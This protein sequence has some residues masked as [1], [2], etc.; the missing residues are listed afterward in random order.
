[1]LE[2]AA[3]EGL[4]PVEVT[5]EQFVKSCNQWEGLTLEEYTEKCLVWETSRD[6]AGEVVQS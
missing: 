6:G 4:Q 2:Q 3:P 1:M 5:Q